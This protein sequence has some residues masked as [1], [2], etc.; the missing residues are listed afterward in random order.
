MH[1][2][3]FPADEGFVNF[4]F[5][6]EFASKELVLHCQSDSMQHEPCRLLSD[7]EVASNFIT[8][9]AVLAVRE[10]PCCGKPLVQANRGILKDSPNLDGELAL[11][12]M[13]STLPSAP[14]GI[15]AN[16]LRSAT[17]T[18]NALRPSPYRKVVDAVVRIRKVDNC[19][20]KALRFGSH[21]VCHA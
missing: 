3:R 8:A 21:G 14:R 6:V 5:A 12:V 13:A 15:E 19:F 16:L 18:R 7:L 10:H 2:P 11:G 4:D 20:L 17:G 1:V 9:D